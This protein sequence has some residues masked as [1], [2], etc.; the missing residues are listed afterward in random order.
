MPFLGVA[1]GPP[2]G[3]VRRAGVGPLVPATPARNI[4]GN[5]AL[6]GLGMS[7]AATCYASG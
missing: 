2:I 1:C 3:D 6:S 5:Q 7:R 4:R